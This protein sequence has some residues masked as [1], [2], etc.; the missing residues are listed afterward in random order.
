MVSA[1]SLIC[2]AQGNTFGEFELLRDLV[3]SKMRP[4]YCRC[5]GTEKN[6]K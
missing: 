2:H 3:E 6:L 5:L 4:F 1:R